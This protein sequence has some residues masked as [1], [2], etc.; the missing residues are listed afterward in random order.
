[1]TVA[2]GLVLIVAGPFIIRV[3]VGPS[4]PEPSRGLL[5]ILAVLAL[6]MAV[7][8][9][10]AMLLNGADVIGF[11][12]VVAT[13]MVV[14]NL[15]LSLALVGPLGVAGPPLATVI[16][17]TITVLIP[18]AIYVR[19]FMLGGQPPPD[20]MRGVPLVSAP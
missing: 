8:T 1:M 5:A 20:P 4:V 9:T 6:V 7:S 17:Q 3:W 12:V 2:A 11:Q 18:C 16:A 10:I 14:A 13:V 15:A 19:R